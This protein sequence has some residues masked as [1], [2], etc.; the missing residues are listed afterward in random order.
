MKVILND[1]TQD[2]NKVHEENTDENFK[3]HSPERSTEEAVST[4]YS[5][6]ASEQRNGG[7]QKKRSLEKIDNPDSMP[8]K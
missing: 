6:V 8:N 5:V 3:S 4:I 2:K 7:T 1:I